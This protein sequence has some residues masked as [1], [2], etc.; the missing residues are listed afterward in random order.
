MLNKVILIASLMATVTAQTKNDISLSEAKKILTKKEYMQY[1][2]DL[3]KKNHK[4][5]KITN[6]SE[7]FYNKQGGNTLTVGPN[8][9]CG[10]PTIQ[11]AINF[12]IPGDTIFVAD[13][14]IIGTDAKLNID[15]ELTLVGGLDSTCQVFTANR[16]HLQ[17]DDFGPVINIDVS[18]DKTV[19]VSGFDISGAQH[20]NIEDYDGGL[21][22]TGDGTV[23]IAN[24]H[25]HD[26][27]SFFGG[28]ITVKNGTEL[29]LN[30]N[31]EI[32]NNTAIS[33]G[34]GIF[35]IDSELN[36]HD[37]LIG[38]FNNGESQG[39]QV[40]GTDNSGGGIYANTCGVFL[41]NNSFG[42]GAVDL[43]YN[44][45]D[46]GAGIFAYN[47]GVS[48][49][50]EGSQMRFNSASTLFTGRGIAIHAQG[51]SSVQVHDLQI[52]D[53]D[54]GSLF[55]AADTSDLSI[56]S[57]CDKSPCSILARNKGVFAW[58]VNDATGLIQNSI[59]KENTESSGASTNQ[60]AV[61]NIENC[62]ISD[63]NSPISGFFSA[64]AFSVMNF[65]NVTVANNTLSN[66]TSMLR[67][68]GANSE[69]NFTGGIIWGNTINI[70][71]DDGGNGIT[72]NHSIIQYDATGLTN[73]IQANPLFNNP[74]NG[75][76]HI[77][78]DSPA[79]D[80]FNSSLNSDFEGDSRP[81]GLL[82]DAGADEWTDLIFKHGFEQN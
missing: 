10:F 37:V 46:S 65:T 72:V 8:V 5:A 16:T 12:A 75:D 55:R 53:N 61:F 78:Y 13:D 58:I 2:H 15:K 82:D 38:R 34:G 39:N 4:K 17:L 30:E 48:F 71:A 41:G 76:Y 42:N 70:L 73:T 69:I 6:Y 14:L 31:T 1:T 66:A 63:Y 52:T 19:V 74:A 51:N 28:G 64:S 20:N 33:N 40:T 68:I 23:T 56:T 29:I 9:Q 49:A 44:K 18:G 67:T 24:S 43:S 62:I 36:A 21:V 35:C 77:K 7:Q 25:I 59:I 45:S 79:R 27:A 57:T 50:F 60:N 22:I 32:Y 47:S 80:H 81:Q 3:W 54:S 26:N 11:L